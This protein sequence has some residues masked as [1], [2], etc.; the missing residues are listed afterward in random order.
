MTRVVIAPG[1]GEPEILQLVE[2]ERPEPE[3]GQVRIAVRAA[4]INPADLKR[5]R[6]QFGGKDRMPMRFGSEVSGV[7]T[8]VGAD[9]V[10]PL[11]AIAL[12]DEVIGY[13]VSGGYADEVVAAGSSVLPKPSTLSW[14]EA[15]GLMVAGVTA[16][17]LLEATG[18]GAGD[19]IVVHGASGSVGAMAVQLARV[20][21]AEVVGTAG[22]AAQERVRALGATPVRYGPG[23]AD[24]IR[25][26][27]PDGVDAALDTVGTDEALDVSAEL[28]TDRTRIA[29]IAGFAR[30]AELGIAA[31]GSGPGADPGTELR[32]A[33]RAVLVD[34]AE[35]GRLTVSI[36]REFPLEEVA[37][38][39]RLVAS[40]HPGGK[41]VLVPDQNRSNQ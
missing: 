34:L 15:A 31:L 41:V 2:V 19:R 28:V 13:R 1:Y 11:G 3:P 38:A 24:R 26:V 23:L 21:G 8:A 18:V 9:A 22:D 10:G 16:M 32:N 36:A 7:V 40:G 35:Q 37:A 12:G 4:A 39:M 30:A 20:R 29:T 17:H 27:F 25:A 5:L 33:A 6:G 14:A